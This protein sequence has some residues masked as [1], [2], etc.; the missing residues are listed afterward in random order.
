MNRKLETKTG[1]M[2]LHLSSI[3]LRKPTSEDGSSINTLIENCNPL[4][5]NSL[6]CNLLQATH[7]ADT[8]ILAETKQGICGFVS[9]YILPRRPNTLFVWQ[10]AVDASARGLGLASRMLQQLLLNQSGVEYLHT[11]ITVNNKA[12]WKT[13][14]R[15]ARDLNAPL[16]QQE[17]FNKERHLNGKHASEMLVVIGPF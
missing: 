4:D 16:V 7:F 8:A 17:F 15:L 14:E 9:S 5:T 3:Q 11:T 2:L 12:S 6:Y 13:F 1:N 10:V